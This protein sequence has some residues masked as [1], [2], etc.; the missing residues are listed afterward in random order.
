MKKLRFLNLAIALSALAFV[1]CDDDGGP[2]DPDGSTPDGMRIV[3]RRG[4]RGRRNRHP[5]RRGQITCAVTWTPEKS[6]LDGLVSC[7]RS[8]V[9]IS[10]APPST[11]SP[12]PPR[13]AERVIVSRKGTIDAQGTAASPHRL[14]LVEPRRRAGLMTGRPCSS[15]PRDQQGSPRP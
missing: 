2:S 15:G 12:P 9:T 7:T 1:G 11:A 8:S 14:H 3:R 13:A 6:V 4:R 10:R 5:S